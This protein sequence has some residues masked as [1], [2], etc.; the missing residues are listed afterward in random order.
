MKLEEI[1]KVMLDYDGAPVGFNWRGKQFLVASKPVR[2][3]SRKLWWEEA[4]SAQKGIGAALMEIEMWRMW[5]LS[6]Q[7][8]VFFELIHNQ[9]QDN[10]VIN[11]INRQ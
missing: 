1:T 8:R 4:E 3:Y 7:D 10:W 11:Q 5:A 6:E 2:W 9:P